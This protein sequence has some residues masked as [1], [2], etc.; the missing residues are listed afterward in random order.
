MA[1]AFGKRKHYGMS[2]KRPVISV[3]MPVYNAEKY[4]AEAV[5]SILNQTFKDFEFIIINDG[6]TDGSLTILKK[7]A[8]QDKR[9]RLVSRDNK[10][11][12]ATLNEGIELAHTP[13]I[14]RMD[15]DDISLPERF[16]K[17]YEYMEA[18]PECVACGTSFQYILPDGELG[19]TFTVPSEHHLID[20]SYMLKYKS[21]GLLHPTAILRRLSMLQ[22]NGY[23]NEFTYAED[24]D[25]FLRLAEIGQLSNIIEVL[26]R[27]RIH[28]VNT[29]YTKRDIQRKSGEEG[30]LQACE[31]RGV[32]K[33]IY[34]DMFSKQ[35]GETSAD[36]NPYSS[37]AW[38]CLKVRNRK[39]AVKYAMSAL[40][41][42][43]FNK[44]SW[45]VL[46]CAVRGY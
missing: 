9:I 4:V 44:E 1:L 3:L 28:P 38:M 14:A 42:Q 23:R 16:E 31:R 43:P 10:G 36:E 13:Y 5:E 17:Q 39:A 41:I 11:L 29:K 24:N 20:D 2:I 6:S 15:A 22:I 19:P 32:D 25:L 8:E 30:I 26:F 35:T 46:Y 27:Y 7:Y 45:R 33:Q 12:I 34:I 40:K 18:H 21:F 37:I